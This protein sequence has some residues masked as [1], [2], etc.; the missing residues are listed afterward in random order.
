MAQCWVGVSLSTCR[1]G[2]HHKMAAHAHLITGPNME[3]AADQSDHNEDFQVLFKRV[4]VKKKCAEGV[5][6]SVS[7]D[8]CGNDR[9]L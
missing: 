2:F 5:Y 1:S 4:F 3:H 7:C 8:Y 6:M 9:P